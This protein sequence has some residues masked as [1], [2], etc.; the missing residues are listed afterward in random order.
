MAIAS[1][2][3]VAMGTAAL[4]VIA[5]SEPG[6]PK[7]HVDLNDGGIWVTSAKEKLFGRLNKPAGSIDAAMNSVSPS[8]SLLDTRQSGAAVVAWEPGAGKLYPIDVNGGTIARNHAATVAASDDLAMGGETLAVLDPA[9]GKVRA[10]KVDA[11]LGVNDLAGVDSSAKALATVERT[12]SKSDAAKSVDLA[13]GTDGTVVVAST[14]GE[15]VTISP[16]DTGFAAPER[17]TIGARVT[18]VQ[19]TIVGTKVVV[20]DADSGTLVLPGGKAVSLRG[21]TDGAQLQAPAPDGSSV[22]VATKQALVSFDLGSGKSQTLFDAANGDPAE[23]TWLN[24]CVYAAWAGSPGEFRYSCAGARATAGNVKNVETLLQPVFRVNRDQ[25]VLNDL[26]SGYVLD[27]ESGNRVDNWDQVKP[28]PVIED[29]DNEESQNPSTNRQDQPPKAVDDSLGARPGRTTVLHVLDNDSDPQGY[30]LSITSVAGLDDPNAT[31]GV[32]PDGQTVQLTLPS[33]SRGVHFSYTIDDG[34]GLSATANVEVRARLGTENEVPHLRL[35]Y[36]PTSWTVAAGGTLSLPVLGDWR[37]PDGDPV[38]L[39]DASVG[40]GSVT[41]TPDGRVTFAAPATGGA[42]TITYHVS[43]GFAGAEPVAATIET[44]VLAPDSTDSVAPKAEPDIA[45][46]VVGKPITVRPLENDLPGVDTSNPTARLALAAQLASP[47]GT[48]VTTDL[49]SGQVTVVANRAGSFELFYT[50]S[51]GNAPFSKEA[52]IRVDAVSPPSA[53]PPP[54]AVPDNAVIHGQA[55]NV[56]DVLANDFDPTGGVLVV[57][58]ATP[59]NGTGQVQVGIVQ[60]RW[61]RVQALAPAVSPNPQVIRYT[62]TNGVTT[63]VSGEV[64]VTQLPAVA[65]DTPVP[66][67]DYAVV[68]AGD[69]VAVP[70]LDN[71]TNPGGSPITLNPVVTGAPVGQLPVTSASGAVDKVGDAY[72]SGQLVR[73]VPPPSV[74]TQ[75]SV[76]V[77]YVA[78][79]PAGNQATGHLH[80][81]IM[82]EPTPTTPDLPPAPQLIEGRVVAGDRLKVTIPTSG[83]DPDGDSVTVLGIGSTP[84]LGR[85]VGVSAT[86][87]TYEAFPSSAGTDSFTYRVTDRFDKVGEATI[88]VAVVQPGTPQAPV[89]VDDQLTAAPGKKVQADVLANDV[90]TPG[91]RVTIRA[92]GGEDAK[93]PAG[94]S[95]ASPTGP[96]ELTAP[97][98][99][100]KPLVVL[101]ELTNGVGEPSI[102]TLTVRAQQNFNN[103]PRAFDAYAQPKRGATSARVNVLSKNFDPE[104]STIKLAEMPGVKVSGKSAIVDITGHAYVVPYEIADASGATAAAVIHVPATGAGAPFVKP[105]AQIEIGKDSAIT[106][107]LADYVEDPAGKDV[108]LTTT[109]KISAAPGEG[110]AVVNKGE[111]QLT[112]TSAG[113]YV[114]PAAI[115]FEVTNGTDLRDKDGIAAHLTVPVQVGPDRPVLRCPA[116]P[117]DVVEGGNPIEVDVASV[118]HVW[119]ADR[120]TLDRMK[121]NG[122]WKK[123]ASGV[124]IDGSGSH[125]LTV[126]ASGSAKPGDIGEISVSAAGSDA[127]ASTLSVRVLEAP[128]PTVAPITIDGFRA[129][130]T[131]T[132]DLTRYVRSPLRDPSVKVVSIT[133][134]AGGDANATRSGAKV[135]ITPGAKTSGVLTFSV[136]ITD[137]DEARTDR[138]ATGIITMNVLREPDAP[139]GVTPDRTVLSHTVVLSWGTPANNGAPIDHYT[140]QAD[141]V[142]Q[143]CAASPCTIN[144]LTNGKDYVFTVRAH[145]LAGDSDPS[146]PSP[147]ARPDAVP[148]AVTALVTSNPQDHTLTLTWAAAKV[149]GTPVVNY[150]ITWTG[151]GSMTVDGG[152]TTAAAT[153][154]VNN[155]KYTFTVI[156]TNQLGPGPSSSVEGQSAGKPPT[157]GAPSFSATND[158]SN[159]SRVVVLTWGAVDPNGTAPTSYAVTRSGSPITCASP[160]A[161]TCTDSGI[162]ND[163]TKYAYAVTARNAAAAQDAPNHTSAPGPATSVEATATPDPIKNVQTNVVVSTPN[164]QVPVTFDLGPSHGASSTVECSYSG[165]SCGTFTGLP[166]AGQTGVARTLTLPDGWPGTFTLRTCNGRSAQSDAYAGDACNGGTGPGPWSGANGPPKAPA[167]ASPDCSNSGETFHWANPGGTGAR[168]VVSYNLG[169]EASGN[170]GS[171]SVTV[172][173]P[174]DGH[175]HTVSVRSVDEQGQQSGVLNVVCRRPSPPRK[176]DLERGGAGP[177]AGSYRYRITITNFAPNTRFSGSCHDSV[178]TGGFY[179][180]TI[181]TNSAGTATIEPT[182]CYSADG[183]DH[184]VFVNGVESNHVTW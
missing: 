108:R 112:L 152:A 141:G 102:A 12:G 70:V 21:D 32:S 17:S 33:T 5:L 178:D 6:Y 37:D 109:D 115:G 121:F 125:V 58:Q 150:R 56:V 84:T 64:T 53:S 154:L 46:G 173:L 164:G 122:S 153:G 52:R 3:I 78:Q 1:I 137:V 9:S 50:A 10:Q 180:F 60:G 119:V 92:A 43:D 179:N 45:R 57:Q 19:V 116:D 35:G 138:H 95:L 134:T 114:G 162:A 2:V 111:T 118:C 74:P 77:D 25:I 110:L 81:T 7:Q 94:V 48:T 147:T 18:S 82:P 96:L 133:Q 181:D 90:R 157:P 22:V 54:V 168:S 59:V 169:G 11:A 126:T 89:A 72:V 165:G 159:S 91:E 132:F 30:I 184:W 39:A 98:A 107:D 170:T 65:T 166:T 120:S 163:G 85:I 124:S 27:L 149:D 123:Q 175:D 183:P 167:T 20:L 172:N 36:K 76:V 51:Y 93:F 97:A 135:E 101:Y 139:T 88:R 68:R 156:A 143:Q 99:D 40:A 38:V 105:G 75:R 100:G 131:A 158:T 31:L 47:E 104:G 83:I 34:K 127:P 142:S 113:G 66:Q 174:Q 44:T 117:L 62:I 128:L 176:V 103:P 146:A 80:V 148:E 28:P 144:G 23:P 4:T 136:L 79:D 160:T 14:S 106:I 24:S 67:D 41:T 49:D 129:G 171:T 182:S 73:F 29:V 16:T 140:V 13:V 42:A 161:T 155:N 55:P 15:L 61:L 151:G 26:Q 177:I 86:A 69:A 63:A 8:S 71:D 130:T 87:I 145:N